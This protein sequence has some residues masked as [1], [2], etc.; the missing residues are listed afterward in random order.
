MRWHLRRV[1]RHGFWILLAVAGQL[2]VRALVPY[3]LLENADDLAGNFLQTFGGTYGVIVAFVM[4]MVWQE[5]NE[6]QLTI[7][8]EAT[9]LSELFRI[10]GFMISWPE[11]RRVRGMLLEYALIVPRLNDHDGIRDPREEREL[12]DL[13]LG[14]YLSYEPAEAHEQRLYDSGVELFRQ[15]NEAREHRE[16]VAALRLPR[17]LRWF[18]FI[19]AAISVC[20]LWV[21]WIESAVIQALLT[22]C[23]TWVVV[24][25]STLVLDLDN[26]Y[27]GDFVV[28]WRRFQSV[29]EHMKAMH[30]P[31][32]GADAPAVIG[33]S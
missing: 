10:L 25:A 1:V 8:R 5:H 15:V 26:P 11:R 13:A 22:A 21:T 4:F 20:T 19:G 27:T 18:V 16:T 28:H 2:A 31:E 12:L 33:S 6:T 30:C 9:S 32:L 7:E 24:A 29:A 14:E 17:A 23:M 3:R